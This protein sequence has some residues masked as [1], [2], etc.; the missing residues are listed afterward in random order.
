MDT[1]IDAIPNLSVI[2]QIE[3]LCWDTNTVT[4]QKVKEFIDDS[5]IL[6]INTDVIAWCISA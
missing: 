4:E 3:L 5:I 6:D 2:T 1:V